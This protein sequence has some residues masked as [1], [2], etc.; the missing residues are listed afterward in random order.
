MSGLACGDAIGTDRGYQRH[1]RAGE[2]P[3]RCEPC[4]TGHRAAHRVNQ[5]GRR[6]DGRQDDP[7]YYRA[8]RAALRWV[9]EHHPD[10]AARIEADVGYRTRRTTA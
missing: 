5:A 7:G 9:H 8:A 3:V 10:Q 4:R 2:R 6:V 1:Q